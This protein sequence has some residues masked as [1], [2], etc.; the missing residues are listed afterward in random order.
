MT[1]TECGVLFSDIDLQSFV[2]H[3]VNGHPEYTVDTTYNSD[4]TQHIHR[5]GK[6]PK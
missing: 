6:F 1:S 4:I 3:F 5:C 2:D